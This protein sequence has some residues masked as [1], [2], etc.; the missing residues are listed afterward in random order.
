[1]ATS[2]TLLA[3]VSPYRGGIAHHSGALAQ[4]LAGLEEC[5]LAVESFAR[6]YPGFLYP[7]ESPEDTGSRGLALPRVSRRIDTLNPLSWRAAARRIA[8]RGGILAI[9][10]WT[11]FAAPCL[12]S[13]ARAAQRNGVEV[14]MLVHNVGDHEGAAWKNRLTH[15][16]LDAATRFVT[17]GEELAGELRQAGFNRPILIVPHPP[18]SDFPDAKG[19]L[20]REKALELLCFGLVRHYKGV[21]IAV[22]ALAQSGQ[23]DVRLTI[24][25]EIWDG[26]DNLRALAADP[27]L[28]GKIEL[29]NAYQSDEDAAE[30]FHRADAIVLPYRSIT[31]SG[32]LAMAQHYRRP[33]IA[34]DLPALAQ[35]I[36]VE[37]MGWTFPVEDEA[38]LAQL[39]GNEVTRK[40]CGDLS[41]SMQPASA[42]GWRDMARAVLG[43]PTDWQT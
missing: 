37:G 14:V 32:V 21:D 17:H 8:K 40:S 29:R 41:A 9:P 24:A 3:P 5:D 25:G 20:E 11:F 31:G 36:N 19:A 38:A 39:L 16:Q 35:P 12:G 30:L 33:V 6:L 34:S 23:E 18:Y 7:G 4:A 26:E 2:V 43:N 10:C 15:W 13:I 28:T 42:E 27:R 1:M 22:E